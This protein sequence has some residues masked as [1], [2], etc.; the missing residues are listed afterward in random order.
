MVYAALAWSLTA[1]DAARGALLMA[2]FGLGTLPMLLAMGAAAHGLATF[3]RLPVVRQGA[4]ILLLLFGLYTLYT[5]GTRP[6]HEA[7]HAGQAYP[8]IAGG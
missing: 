6:A 2:A 3:V 8:I 1:G 7:Q 5:A 4:G